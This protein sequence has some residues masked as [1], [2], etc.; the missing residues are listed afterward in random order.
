MFQ[1]TTL[2]TTAGEIELSCFIDKGEHELTWIEFHS[3][4]DEDYPDQ[5]LVWDNEDFLFD[6]FYQFLHRWKNRVC[7]SEDHSNF[8]DIWNYFEGNEDLIDELIEMFDEALKQKW[9]NGK[10]S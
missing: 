9:Y 7:S 3:L 5:D 4:K 8:K 6:D 10:K 1:T 2:H